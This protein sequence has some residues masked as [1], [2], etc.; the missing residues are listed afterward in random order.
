VLERH[1]DASH[2]VPEQRVSKDGAAAE[3][4]GD[5]ADQ[6]GSDEEPGEHGGDE[7][8]D[9]GS[10][11]KNAGVNQARSNVAGEE[12]IVELEEAAEGDESN[13]RPHTG[14]HG[15]FKHRLEVTASYLAMTR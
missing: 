14:W 8:R 6:R 13:A 5:K 9:A 15:I 11:R 12:D 1:D 2:G 3:A 7:T 10:R 4:V